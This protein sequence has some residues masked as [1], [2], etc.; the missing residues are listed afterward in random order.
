MTVEE[1]AEKVGVN[2]TTYH[3]WVS[4][5]QKPSIRHTRAL[6]ELAHK[7]GVIQETRSLKMGA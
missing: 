7:L 6:W 2:R 4:G 3:A 5:R 1:F